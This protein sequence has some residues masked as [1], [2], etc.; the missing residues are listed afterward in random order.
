VQQ[1]G[2]E[3]QLGQLSLDEQKAILDTLAEMFAE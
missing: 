2:L 3:K 1:L